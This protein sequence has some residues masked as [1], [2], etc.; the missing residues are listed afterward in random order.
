MTQRKTPTVCHKGWYIQRLRNFYARKIKFTSENFCERLEKINTEFPRLDDIHP[1]YSDLIN[2]LYSKHHY[3]LALSQISVARNL[4]ENIAKDTLHLIKFAET[5]YRCKCLKRAALGRM[6]TV[7]KKLNASLGYLERVR[8]HLSRLPAIDP[9]AKTLIITGFPNVG[10]SSFINK[11]SRAEVDVQPY[12][13][14]TKSIFV[15]HFDYKDMRW[16]VVDTP[17]LLDHSLK[18]RNTIEMQAITA[19]AHINATVLYFVDISETCGKT[20]EQQASLYYNIRPLFANKPLLVVAN[21]TDLTPIESLDADK[22][23]LL[24]AIAKDRHTQVMPMSN[25]TEEG[26]HKVKATACDM[27]MRVRAEQSLRSSKFERASQLIT[28]SMPTPRDNKVRE[29]TIPKAIQERREEEKQARATLVANFQSLGQDDE[30]IEV[31]VDAA[32]KDAKKS[33]RHRTLKDLEDE[34]GGPGQFDFDRRN[35][36]DLKNDEWKFDVIPEFMDGKNVADFFDADIEE[37]L[38]ELEREEEELQAAF[39]AS[40]IAVEDENDELTEEQFMVVSAIRKKQALLKNEARLRQGRGR[41]ST[42]LAKSVVPA[43]L[44]DAEEK[45]QEL[46]LDTSAMSERIKSMG[47]PSRGRKRTRDEDDDVTR[48][49]VEAEDALETALASGDKRAISQARHRSLSRSVS[50]VKARS[51]S[52]ARGEAPAAGEGFQDHK[53]KLHAEKLEKHKSWRKQALDAR[54]SESDRHVFDLKPKHLF[55]G[56]RGM[57]TT[58]RR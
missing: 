11:V 25:I 5:Q 29:V 46:G 57:G 14:T 28:V 9:T 12:A 21:K 34:A 19:L 26:I 43:R 3:K 45:L 20:I 13:F 39:E 18:D 16:Q 49:D 23:A 38:N 53:T 55:S 58:D 8:Q 40:G 4:I 6:V 10:K 22:R 52:R 48:A 56:K 24:D 33:K 15:G 30:T 7:T 17:G 1:Y 50:R 35:Y 44:E 37:K 51:Q 2:V 27:M 42:T 47:P 41:N 54:Q 36:F 31:N 32:M